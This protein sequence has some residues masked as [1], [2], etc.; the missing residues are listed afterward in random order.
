MHASRTDDCVHLLSRWPAYRTSLE[1]VSQPADH[2]CLVPYG[3]LAESLEESLPDALF[4]ELASRSVVYDGILLNRHRC[5][6]TDAYD[7]VHI[8]GSAH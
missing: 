1:V 3:A 6:L 5:L 4:A 2:G 7:N 8:C